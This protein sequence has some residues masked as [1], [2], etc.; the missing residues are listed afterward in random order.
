MADSFS[1]FLQLRLPATGAYNNTWGATLNSDTFSLVDTAVTGWTVV[2]IAAAVSYSLPAQSPG[3]PS[4]SRYFS[5]L[6]TGSPAA[7]VT[8]TIPASIPGKMY[9]VNNQTGQ[10]LLFTYAGSTSTTIVA[11]QEIRLIWA[12]GTNVY[13]VVANAASATSLGG[14]PAANWMRLSRTAAEITA[15]TV[16]KNNASIPTAFAYVTATEAPTTVLDW[17]NGNNQKLTLT[18]NR[19]MGAP[20]N[21]NDGADID[22]IVIQ[23]GTGTRTLSWNAIFLFENGLTP[24]LATAPGAIDRFL[25]KY[26]AALN[27]WTVG[28]FGNLNTGAGTTLPI[29]VDGN[30]QDWNLKAIIGTLGSPATINILVTKGTVIESS[31]P[32]TP[33]M[34]LSGLISGCTVNLTNLGYIQG[35]GGDGGDGAWA[36]Y[37]GSGDTIASAGAALAGT[38]AIKGPGSGC[39]FNITNGA[40][41]IWGGG[42][43]GG[44]AGAFSGSPVNG[45]GNGGGGGGGAGGGRGGRG[46]RGVFVTGG[47]TNATDG[48]FG[49]A[50]VNGTFG[51]AGAGTSQGA[52]DSGTAGAG[53]DWGTA[54]A[55]GTAA[56]GGSGGTIGVFSAGGGAGKAI[57]L[58]GGAATFVTGAGSPNVKG[59]VS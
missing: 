38:M 1:T 7:Q 6:F 4:V 23:D 27:K 40:G 24:V 32:G 2:N 45:L 19:V 31:W 54:G 34:D 8:V 44:G 39:T 16:V 50:G 18:G 41:F 14:I 21:V 26:N 55:T 42:G 29:T 52:G 57:E 35:H 17:N 9:L 51:A 22:L 59:S 5:L 46:A 53:G 43:G 28:H 12:D 56:T 58:S 49:T 15:A 47:S 10:N 11:D 20:V 48:G 36:S 33:A 30:T 25:L 3:A 37:P 13:A